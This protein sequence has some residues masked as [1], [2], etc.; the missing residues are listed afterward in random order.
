MKN[1]ILLLSLLSFVY[2]ANSQVTVQFMN[3]DPYYVHAKDLT[4]V[5]ITNSFI[6]Y[7]KAKLVV[8]VSF[9]EEKVCTIET[10]PIEIKTGSEFYDFSNQISIINWTRGDLKQADETTSG[11]LPG[12]YKICYR[13][14]DMSNMEAIMDGQLCENIKIEFPTPLLLAYPFD[15]SEIEDKNPVFSWIAPLPAGLEKNIIY[16]MSLYEN[17]DKTPKS[18]VVSQRPITVIET[19]FANSNLPSTVNEL[20]FGVDYFWKVDA[21]IGSNY[22]I[23]SEVWEFKLK[24]PKKINVPEVYV[25][26]NEIKDD[27]HT[28][29]NVLRVMYISEKMH[30][31]MNYIITNPS[32]GR[33]LRNSTISYNIGENAWEIPIDGLNLENE[34]FLIIK[35]SNGTETYQ[36]KFLPID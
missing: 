3:I 34:R 7:N 32:D 33:I 8:T 27:V 36:M 35:F 26:I 23:S 10:L 6:N 12:K 24:E 13:L 29:R 21:Y 9:F 17:T 25:K 30:G 31:I 19:N 22:L 5:I 20:K 1:A 11:M 4:K 2:K 16:K 18:A 28:A 14:Y 15:K